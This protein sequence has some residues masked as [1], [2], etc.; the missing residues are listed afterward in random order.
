MRTNDDLARWGEPP[1][2]AAEETLAEQLGETLERT[3]FAG[4]QR[5][6]SSVPALGPDAEL[7]E[8]GSWLD[9]LVESVLEQS[10][11]LASIAEL[12]GGAA[13]PVPGPPPATPTTWP[14]TLPGRF[15]LRG[16]LGGDRPARVWLAD[17]LQR[18]RLVVLKALPLPA[19]ADSALRRVAE[20]RHPNLLRP[21]DWLQAGADR[22]LVLPYLA[23]GSFA[24]RLQRGPLAPLRGLRQVADVGEA[25]AALHALGLAHGGVCPDNLLWA[26]DSDEAVLTSFSVSARLARTGTP[27]ADVEALAATLRALVGPDALPEPLEHSSAGAFAAALRGALNGLLADRIAA[28][29]PPGGAAVG[30]T[31]QVRRVPA[32]PVA[33]TS[34]AQAGGVLRDLKRPGPPTPHLTLFIGDRVSLE[35]SAEQPG[36]VLV[37]NVGPLGQLNLLCPELPALRPGRALTVPDV[38]LTP[39]AGRERLLAVWLRTP[40]ALA[41]LLGPEAGGPADL[42]SPGYRSTRQLE[43]LQEALLRLPAG[44]WQAV[45]L[46]A[47]T[48]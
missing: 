26:P 19:D 46:T 2:D 33:S 1:A 20:L 13:P 23:G 42:V 44:S 11:I 24:A 39:P 34:S 15:R 8:T 48:R 40:L 31:L 28:S 10:G 37:V 38:E 27:A 9:D 6:G 22:F 45:V 17:D 4:A 29:R 32:G 21:L 7:L 18:G 25:L 47:T 43:R 41:D 3:R 16:P 5:G 14:S 36:H 35:V 30:L 12:T